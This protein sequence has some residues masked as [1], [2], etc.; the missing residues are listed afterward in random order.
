MADEKLRKHIKDRWPSWGLSLAVHVALL[1]LFGMITW[2]VAERRET[3]RNLMLIGESTASDQDGPLGKGT[4]AG[5]A[6]SEDEIAE[7]IAQSAP[8]LPEMRTS[9]PV[10]YS[11][12]ALKDLSANLAKPTFQTDSYNAL[13]DSLFEASRTFAG[14]PG[15]V[16]GGGFGKMIG[17]M[18]GRG[19]DVVFV[20]DATDSMSPYIEQ[21]KKRLQQVINVVTHLVPKARFG[22][23]AYKDY[24]DDYGPKAVKILPVT[25]DHQVVRKFISQINAGGGAD[26]PEPINE[27]LAIIT[28]TKKMGWKTMRIKVVILVGDSPIHPSGRMPAFRHARKFAKNL[29]GTINV[30]DTG[31]AGDQQSIRSSVQPDLERIAKDGGGSAFLLKDKEAFWRHLIVSVFGQQYEQDVS[32]IIERYAH[33]D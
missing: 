17:R 3:D 31:G 30:I 20:L 21:S 1:V 27:A 2:V 25:S 18:R 6:Q 32:T 12:E 23:V 14:K 24:G 4:D 28:N 13:A 8:P 9:E 5:E 29:R 19:L 10:S 7:R 15:T 33:E 22:V 11:P 26:T 16:M